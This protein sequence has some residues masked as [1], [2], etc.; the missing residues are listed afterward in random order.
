MYKGV[1]IDWGGVLTTGMYDSIM[2]WVAADR[3][4]ANRYREVMRDMVA[5]AYD[6]GAYSDR[7]DSRAATRA[8]TRADGKP[9][10]RADGKAAGEP[11]NAAASATAITVAALESAI[12]DEVAASARS[13]HGP[14]FDSPV[15]PIH[16]LERGEI[17][18]REFERD[19]ASRLLTLDGVPPLADGLLNRM[20]AAFEPV[21]P[22]YAMLRTARAAGLKTCLLSNS[23]GNDYPRES[24]VGAF[25]EVVI[26]GEV[27]M[28]KP[29]ARIF[30]HTL[31]VIGLSPGQCVFVDDIVSNIAAAEALGITGV[32][33]TDATTTIGELESLL[34][35]PLRVV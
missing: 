29:E 31:G 7:A 2:A 14:G 5:S 17:D 19:L 21:E 15:N 6:E 24:W 4:D 18:P 23:W 3:I 1:L 28:R 30:H 27:G 25:D 9:A 26:S 22:M 8:A 35:V 11:L 13:G 12:M 33:H 32:H 20:F 34:G 10:G 16:A